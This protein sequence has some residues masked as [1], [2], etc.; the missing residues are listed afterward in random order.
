MSFELRLARSGRGPVIQKLTSQA[1]EAPFSA[2]GVGSTSIMSVLRGGSPR[3]PIQFAAVFSHN[4]EPEILSGLPQLLNAEW[5]LV[6]K[7][8]EALMQYTSCRPEKHP[9]LGA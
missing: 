2:N 7:E 5:K 6:V 3:M 9:W 4:V 1:G 8:C